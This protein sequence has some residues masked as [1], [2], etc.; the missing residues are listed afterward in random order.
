MTDRRIAQTVGAR[1]HDALSASSISIATVAEA[2]D[3]EITDLSDRL[4]GR[5]AFT[6]RELVRV[7]GFLHVPPSRF[8]EGVRA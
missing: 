5:S 8:L 7:G 2:T 4:T 1:V 6:V 3:L